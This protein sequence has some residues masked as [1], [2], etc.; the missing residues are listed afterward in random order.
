MPA[1]EDVLRNIDFFASMSKK[2]QA[3]LCAA[4]VLFVMVGILVAIG[5]ISFK[6]VSVKEPMKWVYRT[7]KTVKLLITLFTRLRFYD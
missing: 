6:K 7:E 3:V 5:M 1:L 2:V 4:F